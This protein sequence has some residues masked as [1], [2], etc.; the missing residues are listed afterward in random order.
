MN[1]P[2]TIATVDTVIRLVDRIGA[3]AAILAALVFLMVLLIRGPVTHLAGLVGN[4][5]ADLMRTATH[6]LTQASSTLGGLSGH[7]SLEH[8]K[9]RGIVER[10]GASTREHVSSE[11][12]S[13][14]DRVSTAE[15]EMVR[16]VASSTG[17][18]QAVRVADS[19]LSA[20]EVSAP[21]SKGPT[22]AAQGKRATVTT[23]PSAGTQ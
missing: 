20:D 7:V 6:F 17:Q 14:R 9:T 22:T 4:A 3:P 2:T 12:R 10:E 13:L 21:A 23:L 1:D 18:H 5:A 16:A 19:L 11:V 15:N 8:E